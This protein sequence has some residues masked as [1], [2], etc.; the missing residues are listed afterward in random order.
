MSVLSIGTGIGIIANPIESTGEENAYRNLMGG[1]ILASGAIEGGI[2]IP[3]L[4]VSKRKKRERDL[5]LEKYK[6]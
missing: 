1:F 6:N 3:L 4:F 5:L 2:G